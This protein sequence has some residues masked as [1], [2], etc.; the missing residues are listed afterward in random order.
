MTL[1]LHPEATPEP[2]VVRWR[3]LD[4]PAAPQEGVVSPLPDVLARLGVSDIVSEPN[5][6]VVRLS[7]GISWRE[8][9]GVV[10]TELAELL[11]S[12]QWRVEPSAHAI[13]AE[14]DDAAIEAAA[15]AV[16]A[17]EIDHVAGSHGGGV[18]LVGVA[19][20]VVSVELEG[21]CDGCPAAAMTLH[22]RFESTLRQ[23]VT[24]VAEVVAV[25]ASC[26]SGEAQKGLAKFIGWP[27]DRNRSRND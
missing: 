18:R 9:G 6:L 25:G 11:R 16:I 8:R 24:G 17:E 22:R 7:D 2:Q 27:H 23:R 19:E 10:R 26:S 15:R 20:G 5:A 12:G 14:S 3:Y 4:A 13:V 21:A 1:G